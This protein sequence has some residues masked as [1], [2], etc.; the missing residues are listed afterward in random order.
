MIRSLLLA[1]PLVM[2][3]ASLAAAQT[4]Q[5]KAACRSDAM[6]Y[7]SS[8]IGKPEAMNACLAQNKANLSDACRKVVE[9]RGG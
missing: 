9:A 7:C 4:A 8:S 5:E 6:K 3:G 2:A 1:L